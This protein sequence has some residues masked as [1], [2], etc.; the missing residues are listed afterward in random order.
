MHGHLSSAKPQGSK[1]SAVIVYL[2]CADEAEVVDLR[3]SVR[4][5]YTHF[6]GVSGYPV[7]VFH[8]ILNER[9]EDSLRAE[10]SSAAAT[11]TGGVL[12]PR[13]TISF[14]VLDAS[15]FA[16]PA[17]LSPTVRAAIPKSIRGYGMG[18]RHVRLGM[19]VEAHSGTCRA[20]TNVLGARVHATLVRTVN[21]CISHTH[22]RAHM[23]VHTCTHPNLADNG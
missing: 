3:R 2:C 8:D 21:E 16:L 14:V 17:H 12:T 1:P 10:A 6:N 19:P 23:R 11:A 22:G 13:V 15:I 9:D 4:L 5:L 7:L 18:Y 20:C